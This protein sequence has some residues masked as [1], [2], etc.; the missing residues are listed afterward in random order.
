MA[1]PLLSMAQI[2]VN[3]YL[4]G[5]IN[6]KSLTINLSQWFEFR[7]S[8]AFDRKWRPYH[9]RITNKIINVHFMSNVSFTYIKFSKIKAES[10]NGNSLTGQTLLPSRTFNPNNYVIGLFCVKIQL[11][12]IRFRRTLTVPM[13]RRC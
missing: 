6:T 5:R 1:S 3:Y 8:T 9:Q 10:C 2:Q 12:I 4:N 7:I 13:Q 11:Q